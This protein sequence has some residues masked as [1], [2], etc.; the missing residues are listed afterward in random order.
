MP[1]WEHDSHSLAFSIDGPEPLHVL[2]NSYWEPLMFQLPPKHWRRLIDTAL[3][4]PTDFA[5]PGAES[6]VAEA[7]YRAEA[8]SVVVLTG[9]A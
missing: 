7:R 9:R 4:S 1:D 8:R 2:V 6:A 3:E 5:D